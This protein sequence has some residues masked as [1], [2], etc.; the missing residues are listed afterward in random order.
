M[1]LFV[2][3]QNLVA[4]KPSL[5]EYQMPTAVK[6]IFF[7]GFQLSKWKV[8]YFQRSSLPATFLSEGT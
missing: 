7:F 1:Y 8:K 3:C 6:A 2:H 4:E 5:K